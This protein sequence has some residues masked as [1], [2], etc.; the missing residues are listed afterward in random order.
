M[1]KSLNGARPRANNVSPAKLAPEVKARKLAMVDAEVTITDIATAA[2]VTRQTAWQ[3]YRG[4]K[5]SRRVKE[6]FAR[7]VGRPVEELFP[8]DEKRAA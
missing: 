5:Q 7:L 4:K 3:V 1:R 2:G 8:P 6:T